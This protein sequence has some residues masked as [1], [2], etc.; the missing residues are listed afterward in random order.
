MTV[1]LVATVEPNETLLVL[2][3]PVPV[4]VTLVPPAADPLVGLMPVTVGTF[5]GVDLETTI[6]VTLAEAFPPFEVNLMVAEYCPAVKLV[7]STFTLIL[8]GN[9]PAAIFPLF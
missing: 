3:K 9:A 4:M 6:N 7:V 1:K 5:A 2:V 8:C